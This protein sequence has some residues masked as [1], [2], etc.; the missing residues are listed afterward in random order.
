MSGVY[1]GIYRGADKIV[2]VFKN[3]EIVWSLAQP[4]T[5]SFKTE[6]MTSP[7]SNLLYLP[8]DI[9]EEIKNKKLLKIEFKNIG[10]INEEDIGT[11]NIAQQYLNFKGTLDNLINASEWINIGTNI[12]IK[13]I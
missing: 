11:I 1:K 2:K 6:R 9:I 13:Y 3:G 12:E 8:I 4:K 7:Y 10:V 5:I